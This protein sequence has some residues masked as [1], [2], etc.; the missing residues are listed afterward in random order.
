[1]SA[2]KK[3]KVFYV[4]NAKIVTYVM[5]VFCQCVK[6]VYVINVLIAGRLIGRKASLKLFPYI[7]T[8]NYFRTKNTTTSSHVY[9]VRDERPRTIALEAMTRRGRFYYKLLMTGVMLS[10]S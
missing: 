6:M 3:K 8:T 7:R 9:N 2:L 10:L 5:I 1:M 4:Q